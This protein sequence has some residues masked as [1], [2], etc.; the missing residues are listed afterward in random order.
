MR[1]GAI[2]V[3]DLVLREG[4]SLAGTVRSADGLALAGIEVRALMPQR[5]AVTGE[6]GAFRL[7]GFD[8]A[9]GMALLSATDPGGA[10]GGATRMVQVGSARPI[11][12]VLV[13]GGALDGRVVEAAGGA[14]VAGATVMLLSVDGDVGASLAAA[15]QPIRASSDEDGRF[16]AS[17][18]RAGR[19]LGR[20]SLPGGPASSFAA[21][22]RE[23]ETSRVEV[24]VAAP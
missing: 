7:E 2:A 24:V 21:V 9:M 1:E 20:A 5:A 13:E 23:D 15:M 3:A 4:V 10:Y 17:G 16:A 6:D 19:Y 12:I 22:V 18:L 11:V 14:A 8:A